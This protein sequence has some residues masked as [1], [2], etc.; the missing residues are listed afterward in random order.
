MSEPLNPARL[1]DLA[2]ASAREAGELVQSMRLDLIGSTDLGAGTKSSSVDL[3]TDAD[4]AAEALIRQRLLAVRPQDGII[5]EEDDDHPS[6]SGVWWV[7]DPIDGTTN[8]VYGLPTYTVSIGAE[9]EGEMMAGAVYHPGQDDMYWAW[10]GGGAWRNDDPISVNTK[11][12]LATSLVATGFGYTPQRRTLQGQVVA[13]LLPHVR[14]IRRS[15]SAALDLCLVA[16]GAV[17]VYYERGLNPWDR[18]AGQIIAAEAGAKVGDLR[19]GAP[20]ERFT[21]AANPALFRIVS[22]LLASYGAD[23][24]EADDQ[25]SGLS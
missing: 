8:Y 14:D 13:Q 2:V 10:T 20:S 4:K 7:I 21:L 16:S 17:D 22:E 25:Q 18:A 9:F 1:A 24:P 3:V 19:G 15:G 23:G 6:E 12:D 5:G 11:T